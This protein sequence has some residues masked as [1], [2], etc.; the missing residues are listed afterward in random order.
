M[1]RVRVGTPSLFA[2]ARAVLCVLLVAVV[3]CGGG[4]PRSLRVSFMVARTRRAEFRSSSSSSSSSSLSGAGPVAFSSQRLSGAESTSSRA[5]RKSDDA[6]S[7][8]SASRIREAT[9]L[10][11]FENFSDRFSAVERRRGG[12]GRRNKKH[13]SCKFCGPHSLG[14]FGGCDWT[15][16]LNGFRANEWEAPIEVDGRCEA[17]NNRNRGKILRLPHISIWQGSIK[18]RRKRPK[19]RNQE[20]TE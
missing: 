18:C 5:Q 15:F 12:G 2:T 11:T 4:S 7:S 17:T 13:S 3:F 14:S 1:R 20:R 8:S 6:S 19:P 16:G 9:F 10:A